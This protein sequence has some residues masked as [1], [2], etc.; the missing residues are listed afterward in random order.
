M[1]RVRNLSYKGIIKNED[2][3]ISMGEI[4][5]ISGPSGCGKS[6]LLS[7]LSGKDY[8]YSGSIELM[9][10]EISNQNSSQI[11]ENIAMLG[12]DVKLLSNSVEGEFD[13]VGKLL[14]IEINENTKL[15]SLKISSL[16]KELSKS[17]D[18]FSGGEKQ[19]LAIA[20]TLAVPRV[21]Y[22]FDEPTSSLDEEST[23]NVIENLY[24]LSKKNDKTIVIVSHDQAVIKDKRFVQIEMRNNGHN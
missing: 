7:L 21:C 23:N 9:G 3:D 12:Q 22:I 6:T 4:N 24:Q 18:K 15:E 5:I 13:T 19:R 16:N 1:Y 14:N 2:I 10:D 20:R 11:F 8:A 17:T